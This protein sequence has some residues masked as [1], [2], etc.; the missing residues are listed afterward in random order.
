ME[1]IETPL[2]SKEQSFL[3]VVP[4]SY[5]RVVNGVLTVRVSSGS[6]ELGLGRI[7]GK[8]DETKRARIIVELPCLP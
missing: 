3:F 5:W 8:F 7:E 1:P 4:A 6:L 2:K